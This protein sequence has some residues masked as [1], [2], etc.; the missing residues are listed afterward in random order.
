ME[1][2]SKQHHPLRRG[3][4]TLLKLAIA[5]V[6]LWYV[7]AHIS[8]VD[9][10]TIPKGAVIRGITFLKN[11]PLPVLGQRRM[12]AYKLINTAPPGKPPVMQRR[13]IGEHTLY[14][15]SFRKQ[16]ISVRLGSG[17]LFTGYAD[18][19]PL[20]FPGHLLLP[21]GD[22]LHA[23]GQPAVE[24]GL[25]GI[26]A[27]AKLPLLVIGLLILGLQFVLTAWR[28][29]RLM[30]V[31][32][33]LLPWGQCLTLTFVGQF[34]STFLPGTTSGDLVKIVYTSRLT[35]RK[36]ASAVTVLLDRVIGLVALMVLGAVAAALQLLWQSLHA[37]TPAD[38]AGNLV[39]VH[40]ILLVGG[41]LAGLAA[42]ATVYFSAR[43]RRMLGVDALMNR[44]PLPDFIKHADETLRA[45]RGHFGVLAFAFAISI[46][47]QA[48]LP[49]AGFLAGR[50]FGMHAPFGCFMAY[51][52]IA[53]LS[54][55][56]PIVPPQGIGVL[57]AVILH[58]FVTRGVDTAGQAFA[59]SQ[60]IRF[61]P[62]M[63]NLVG[64]YWVVRGNYSRHRAQEMQ[65]QD[66]AQA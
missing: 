29:Q 20:Y 45:Y 60:A 55:S 49:L 57:D 2:P 4:L 40:I 36:T 41:L 35:G 64:A 12:P 59:L 18:N 51:I 42:G 6:G 48:I 54:A 58:F 9:R 39:L 61:M 13:K 11:T 22:L 10:A 46:V 27:R 17:K 15:I 1:Q 8:W 38:R 14:D 44:L 28:W 19:P 65:Q 62:I 26:L 56:L 52:P 43:L 33:M 47:S 23:A 16:V 3:L 5:V 34:Y 7:I 30:R 21:V 53:A 66:D 50:A 37:G 31:Q 24:V 25:K 63:W 32:G